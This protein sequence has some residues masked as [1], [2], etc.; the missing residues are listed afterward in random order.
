VPER[1]SP[2]PAGTNRSPERPARSAPPQLSAARPFSSG[3]QITRCGTRPEPTMLNEKPQCPYGRPLDVLSDHPRLRSSPASSVSPRGAAPSPPHPSARI[4]A[5]LGSTMPA[6]QTM[7]RTSRRRYSGRV[8]QPLDRRRN[9]G[10]YG[11]RGFAFSSA[12]L[13]IRMHRPFSVSVTARVVR[14]RSATPIC[15]SRAAAIRDA[16]GCE[17]PISRPATEKLPL[18][19]TRAKSCNEKNLS[20]IRDSHLT[21]SFFQTT[22]NF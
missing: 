10:R 21:K 14:T 3:L 18:L 6:A 4:G 9:G 16:V 5:G 8:V 19:A 13:R 22:A 2:L 15:F 17:T 12:K 1:T 7:V 11:F 20:F